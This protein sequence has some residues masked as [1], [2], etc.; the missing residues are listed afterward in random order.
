MVTMLRMGRV[1]LILGC[2]LFCAP[3]A[4]AANFL[5][6]GSQVFKSVEVRN[7]RTETFRI[8]GA[9]VSADQQNAEACDEKRFGKVANLL[10]TVKTNQT[11]NEAP[12]FWQSE[13]A[14]YLLCG[15]QRPPQLLSTVEKLTVQIIDEQGKELY[16]GWQVVGASCTQRLE[17]LA[18]QQK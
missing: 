15:P 12:A 5:T 8:P 4:L 11:W 10:I 6:W 2:L 3:P 13:I 1:V 9:C 18:A 7:I 16:H 14:T 17:E